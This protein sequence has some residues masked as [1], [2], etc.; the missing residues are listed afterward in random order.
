MNSHPLVEH[1]LTIA[2]NKETTSYNFRKALKLL[3]RFLAYRASETLCLKERVIN[4]LLQDNVSCKYLG[5]NVVLVPILRAGL[6][7]M[8]EFLDILP[9]AE[10]NL[11]GMER[12]DD[13][14]SIVKFYYQKTNISLKDKTVIIL[15]PMIATGTS[16]IQAIKALTNHDPKIQQIIVSSVLMSDAARERLLALDMDL[17]VYTCACDKKLN[18][19][20]FIVPGLGD[21]GDRYFNT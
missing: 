3:C 8:D 16:L 6:A 20:N 17:K 1:W 19:H 10:V 9:K 11:I 4:T 12:V 5:C 7:M 2:R 14:N 15:D 13:I 21:A 18:K